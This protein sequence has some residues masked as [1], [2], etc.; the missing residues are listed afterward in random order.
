MQTEF[1]RPIDTDVI[2]NMMPNA[3]LL[4]DPCSCIIYND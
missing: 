4:S 3:P 1:K 2:K